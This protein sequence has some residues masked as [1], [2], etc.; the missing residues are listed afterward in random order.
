MAEDL[1][2]VIS[3]SNR[4]EIFNKTKKEYQ[5]LYA[6][7]KICLKVKF[8]FEQALCFP[9]HKGMPISVTS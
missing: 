5:Y 4:T 7:N 9:R 3:I 2:D 6:L 1:D 8:N